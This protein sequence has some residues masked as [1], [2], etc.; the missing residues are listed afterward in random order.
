MSKIK[1]DVLASIKELT[2]FDDTFMTKVFEDDIEC[3][4]FLL[5]IIFN[6]DKIKV[7]KDYR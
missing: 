6:D 1:M 4:Q 7:K 5:R 2:L 3:T